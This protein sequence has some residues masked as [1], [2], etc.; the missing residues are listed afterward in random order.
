MMDELEWPRE[1]SKLST[2]ERDRAID[3]LIAIVVDVDGIFLL[4]ASRRPEK[5]LSLIWFTFWSS[6]VHGTIMGI[7]AILDEAELAHLFGDVAALWISVALLGVFTPRRV[8]QRSDH[9]NNY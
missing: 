6:V 2:E 4:R 9:S 8:N 7:Q 1:D 5:H 3:E